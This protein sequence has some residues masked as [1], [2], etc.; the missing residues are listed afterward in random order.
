M[1]CIDVNPLG[2]SYYHGTILDPLTVRIKYNSGTDK[3]EKS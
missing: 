3:R 1:N 2:P